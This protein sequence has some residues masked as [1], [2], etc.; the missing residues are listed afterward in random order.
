MSGSSES[1]SET[2][3]LREELERLRKESLEKKI[4]GLVQE[5]FSTSKII[6][7]LGAA[8]E[9]MREDTR[10]AKEDIV[11]VKANMPPL[12]ATGAVALLALGLIGWTAKDIIAARTQLTDMAKPINEATDKI[13]TAADQSSSSLATITNSLDKINDSVSQG[14]QNFSEF[15][16][17]I[18]S[19]INGIRGLEAKIARLSTQIDLLTA[20]VNAERQGDATN[21]SASEES[22]LLEQV[23][24]DI[25]VRSDP[26]ALLT[27]A[28]IELQKGNFARA[29]DL[30][31]QA[32]TRYSGEPNA[33]FD[34][35]IAQSYAGEGKFKEAIGAYEAALQ[36]SDEETRLTCLVNTGATYFSWANS[37][38]MKEEERK[39]LL[40]KG[41][42]YEAQ[43]VAL[44][45]D[46]PIV[47]SNAAITQIGL[48]S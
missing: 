24:G 6:E 17:S 1:K 40:A 33:I 10:V 29:R 25:G 38:G 18:D 5:F 48:V 28:T 32:K 45:P 11:K 12:A 9:L 34:L 43:A 3:I 37:F 22:M 47:V 19:G 14:D 13:K 42:E 31:S 2:D 27:K 26:L 44:A 7:K 15:Q 46:D 36:N 8:Q 30:A 16:A 4:D 39:E 41:A 21:P 20:Q 35:A 23:L